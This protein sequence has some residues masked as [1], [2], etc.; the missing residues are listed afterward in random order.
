MTK[1][2]LKKIKR[3]EMALNVIT[4]AHSF[5]ELLDRYEVEKELSPYLVN[6]ITDKVNDLIRRWDDE[7]NEEQLDC[8]LDE[9]DGLLKHFIPELR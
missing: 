6:E 4:G 2:E 1:Q 9:M 8:L 7:E 5:Y 3:Q